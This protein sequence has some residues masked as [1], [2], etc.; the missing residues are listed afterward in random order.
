MTNSE[1]TQTIT[2][3]LHAVEHPSIAATLLDLGMV[4]GIEI[5]DEGKVDLT[6]V[7]PF[8][9]IPEQIR[10]HTINGLAQAAKAVGGE[11]VSVKVEVMNDEE[12]QNFMV[13]EQANWRG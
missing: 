8:P 7:I 11:I 12:K 9:A 6:L 10:N 13:K 3:A 1:L 4:R 5:N 2:N